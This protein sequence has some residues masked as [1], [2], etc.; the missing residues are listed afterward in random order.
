MIHVFKTSVKSEKQASMVGAFLNILLP[1]D[2]WN[3]DLEDKDRI[4]RV[5]TYELLPDTVVTI[6]NSQGF[7]CD[8][9]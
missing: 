9:L 2:S 8:E 5:E 3:F 4:L 7:E 6:L 1:Y